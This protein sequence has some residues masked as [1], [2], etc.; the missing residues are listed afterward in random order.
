MKNPRLLILAVLAALAAAG[1]ALL[2]RRRGAT[3]AGDTASEAGR[4]W[5]DPPGTLESDGPRVGDPMMAEAS[6]FP[7]DAT[8]RDRVR[9]ELL[10]D[11]DVPN[12]L[13][14]DCALG[15]VTLR[16]EAPPELIDDLGTRAA[17]VEGVVRVDNRLHAPG[18]PPPAG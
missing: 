6:H 14:I 2:R 17:A 18:I 16:G 4:S 12:G 9:S 3:T 1:A 11:A 13:S 5:P 10:R 7:E 8:I 15:V